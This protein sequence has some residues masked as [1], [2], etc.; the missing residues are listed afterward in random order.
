LLLQDLQS[1]NGT[2]V[3]EQAIEQH[4]LQ[5]GDVIGIG[6]YQLQV[7]DGAPGGARDA[8]VTGTGRGDSLAVAGT[9]AQAGTGSAARHAVV[10]VL[11]GA[12]SGREVLLTKDRTT[13]GKPGVLVVAIDRQD[14]THVLSR[15]EG[16][17]LV[18]VNG[19]P[20]P[21]A[22]VPLHD[23]DLIDLTGTR[24]QFACA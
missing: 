15:V 21:P 20:M 19:A 3:N 1:T 24:L 16:Q 22:G 13:F 9:G 5:P 6:R 12:A 17:A 2:Y 4:L 7:A 10:R 18:R 8:A 23:G 14:G 11:D